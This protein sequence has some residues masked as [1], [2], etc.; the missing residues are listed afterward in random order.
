MGDMKGQAATGPFSGGMAG[1]ACM[2]GQAAT[3]SMLMAGFV[4]AFTIPILILLYTAVTLRSEQASFEQA[5]LSSKMISDYAGEIYVQ[6]NGSS[7]IVAVNYPPS[8]RNITISGH[9][10]I[11][12]LEL[13]GNR[14]D[15][16]SLSL[17]QMRDG[18]LQPLGSEREPLFSYISS[19]IH[20][21]NLTNVDNVVEIS[22]V[23]Q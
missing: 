21:I 22:Y 4:I 2:R 9:E 8:L 15:V 10:I 13:R 23:K 3:E 20:S 16:S 11:F 19:G 5:R 7:R 18:P 12:S 14:T 1:G 6:G 17:A